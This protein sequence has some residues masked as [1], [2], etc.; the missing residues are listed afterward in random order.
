MAGTNTHAC[1]KHLLLGS[2]ELTE[3][4]HDLPCAS[5]SE[6]VAEGDGTT[7]GV[8]LGVVKAGDVV[9]A[10]YGHGGEGLVDLDNIDVGEVKV[11]LGEELGNGDAGADT[12]DAGRKASDGRVDI[13]GEDRLAE[14]ICGRSLHENDGGSYVET[15]Y[16]SKA[17]TNVPG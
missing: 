2:P 12:H 8:H 17:L 9:T 14:L 10:V 1:Q 6:W 3:T 13:F 11:D 7:T 5:G 16:V 15:E 4:R